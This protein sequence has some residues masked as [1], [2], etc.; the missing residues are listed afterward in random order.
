[1]SE[2]NN[3]VNSIFKRN[4]AIE[5]STNKSVPILQKFDQRTQ[6]RD[7]SNGDDKVSKV[8][9]SKNNQTTFQESTMDAQAWA[10]FPTTQ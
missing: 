8:S 1:M 3:P 9:Q 2:N 4:S 10:K 5:K 6:P 7:P